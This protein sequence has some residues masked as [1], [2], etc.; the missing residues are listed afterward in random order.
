[1][2]E[3]EPKLRDF[4]VAARSGFFTSAMRSTASPLP[5]LA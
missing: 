5:S 3:A 4:G 1:M 2:K